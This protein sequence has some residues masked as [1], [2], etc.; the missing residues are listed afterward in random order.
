MYG[1][2][3]PLYGI[4]E[5]SRPAGRGV[6]SNP[7]VYLCGYEWSLYGSRHQKQPSW[8][9][10]ARLRLSHIKL[11][12]P[13]FDCTGDSYMQGDFTSRSW[14]PPTNRTWPLC[15]RQHKSRSLTLSPN[16]I[17]KRIPQDPT[18]ILGLE[19]HKL[20]SPFNAEVSTTFLP[21][22]LFW[23]SCINHAHVL[24]LVPRHES[25][26]K[27]AVLQPKPT[28]MNLRYASP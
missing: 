19:G 2:L 23:L 21:M 20:K 28:V 16:R 13:L 22:P 18:Q 7:R 1:L 26:V 9:T 3:G 25:S 5:S 17:R 6:S 10:T 14:N 12:H 15:F 27:L 24:A 11:G 8:E 4:V